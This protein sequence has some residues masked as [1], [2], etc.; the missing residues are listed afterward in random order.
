MKFFRSK[1]SVFLVIIIAIIIIVFAILLLKFKKDIFIKNKEIIA[2]EVIY[3]MV[4]ADNRENV[5]IENNIKTNVAEKVNGTTM[6]KGVSEED[7]DDK[8][9]ITD[10]KIQADINKDTCSF[11]GILHNDTGINIKNL[12]INIRFY[13]SS[14]KLKDGAEAHCT[15]LEIGSTCEIAF[16]TSSDISNIEYYEIDYSVIE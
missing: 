14:G 10:V 5:Q 13:M 1:K 3:K 12:F 8:I 4:D 11:Y 7:I 2:D 15:N 6:A 16:D 9:Y